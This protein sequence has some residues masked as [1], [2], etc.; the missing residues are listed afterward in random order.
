M[1]KL[2]YAI[3]STGLVVLLTLSPVFAQKVDFSG[4]WILDKEKTDWGTLN[5]SD[6]EI[7]IT[8]TIIQKDINLKIDDVMI[9]PLATMEES[10]SYTLDGK[11]AANVNSQGVESKTVCMWKDNVLVMESNMAPQGIPIVVTYEYYL[12]AD[13]KVLTVGT[14]VSAPTVD[15]SGTLVFKKA[16]EKK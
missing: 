3:I 4:K 8:R 1:K 12:S 10:A 5:L 14:N 11:E 2:F 16:E 6:D 7:D 13:K 9:T 15:M